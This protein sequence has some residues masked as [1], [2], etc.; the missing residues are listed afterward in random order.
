MPTGKAPTVVGV[1]PISEPSLLAQPRAHVTRSYSPFHRIHEHNSLRRPSIVDNVNRQGPGAPAGSEIF[2]S[3]PKVLCKRN[4]TL[5]LESI[6]FLVYFSR[7]RANHRQC[8][9]ACSPGGI[10]TTKY[11]SL[12]HPCARRSKTALSW[13]FYGAPLHHRV[14]FAFD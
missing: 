3:R 2:S 12:N 1:A 8:I 10:S 4:N 7:P 9:T 13:V 11:S 6:Y 5:M 14:A